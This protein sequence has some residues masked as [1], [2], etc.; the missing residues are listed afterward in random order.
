M[1]GPQGVGLQPH[2]TGHI[3]TPESCSGEDVRGL[4]CGAEEGGQEALVG[5]GGPCPGGTAP[6]ARLLGAASVG[7]GRWD[8]PSGPTLCIQGGG[9]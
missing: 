3:S 6:V 4:C 7:R 8:G 9:R 1:G 2:L 5:V